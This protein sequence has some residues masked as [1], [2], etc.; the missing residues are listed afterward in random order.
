MNMDDS[1]DP[2]PANE[3]AGTRKNETVIRDNE[4]RIRQEAI[5]SEQRQEN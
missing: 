1:K 3:Y 4:N 2:K 5:L